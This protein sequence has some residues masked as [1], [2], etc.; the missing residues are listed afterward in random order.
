MTGIVAGVQTRTIL[1]D[2][3]KAVPI[4]D[5]VLEQSPLGDV[6]DVSA[7][8]GGVLVK[9]AGRKPR[10]G[11]AEALEKIP[12]A[13]LDRDHEQLRAF[14]E[15]RDEWDDKEWHWPESTPDEKI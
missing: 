5:A 2:G 11:W 15:T 4:P 12:Q 1:I 10:E 6:V 9:S 8:P 14:R 3:K 13:D 7:V